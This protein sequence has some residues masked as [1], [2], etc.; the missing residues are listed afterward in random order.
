VPG[1]A[2]GREVCVWALCHRGTEAYR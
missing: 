2:I 1:L